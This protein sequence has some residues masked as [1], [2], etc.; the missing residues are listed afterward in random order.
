MKISYHQS[1]EEIRF[2]LPDAASSPVKTQFLFQGQLLRR[3]QQQQQKQQQSV[4][5]PEKHRVEAVAP[6]QGEKNNQQSG[7][8]AIA[9][10][11]DA[12]QTKQKRTLTD[13]IDDILGTK[14]SKKAKRSEDIHKKKESIKLPQHTKQ[15]QQQKESIQ[16]PKLVSTEKTSSPP[17]KHTHEQQ[18]EPIKPPQLASTEKTS[19]SSKSKNNVPYSLVRSVE[20]AV[21]DKAGRRPRSNSTDCELQLPQRG[22]CDESV[23]LR[24]LTWDIQRLYS[25]HSNGNGGRSTPNPPRGF[26]NL[27]NT[28]FLNA[29]LQCLTYLPTFCQAIAALPMSAYEQKQQQQQRK[30]HNGQHITLLLRQI[31]RMQYGI[32]SH[33]KNEQ[34]KTNP[35]T[36]KTLHKKI[37]SAKINGIHF[38][39]GRQ[40]DAHELLVH[41]L[42]A[43]HEGELM[44]A[45]KKLGACIYGSGY[46]YIELY[47]YTLHFCMFRHQSKCIRMA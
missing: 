1:Q 10:R 37:T 23:I 31:I 3:K 9:T 6:K 42:D 11:T 36:P 15:Q 19:S 27:G 4:K 8:H 25:T 20:D 17:A 21:L 13:T 34:P 18:T 22:L 38:R 43:M 30:S 35:I 32:I 39:P 2:V 16:P 7:T 44:A 5:A 12:K 29:T 14:K 28:C 47:S 40:E 26:T 33:E 46:L 24:S 45:G 41:L